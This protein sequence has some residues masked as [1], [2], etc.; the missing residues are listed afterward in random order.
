MRP[1]TTDRG[2]KEMRADEEEEA[3]ASAQKQMI[4]A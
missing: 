2:W 1:V 4:G 3:V